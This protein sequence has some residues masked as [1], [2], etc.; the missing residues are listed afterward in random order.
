MS[1]PLAYSMNKL[2]ETKSDEMVRLEGL[3]DKIKE[4]ASLGRFRI[5]VGELTGFER[6]VLSKY[7]YAFGVNKAKNACWIS[8]DKKR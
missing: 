3:H 6:E 2:A 7:G 4:S 1:L 5:E 8:W